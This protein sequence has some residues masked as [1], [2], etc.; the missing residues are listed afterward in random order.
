MSFAFDIGESTFDEATGTRTITKISKIY[1]LSAVT[2]AAYPQTTIT[3]RAAKNESEVDPMYN[4][5]TASLETQAQN[6]DTCATPEYRAA[7]FKSLL[8]QELTD[9]E[10]RAMTAAKAE[11]RADT[12]LQAI[13][14]LNPAYTGDPCTK[15]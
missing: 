10:T 2:R 8:G 1:E 3:A 5:I 9:S 12:L 13:A 15:I 7:F 11:K 14:K 4:P 6:R